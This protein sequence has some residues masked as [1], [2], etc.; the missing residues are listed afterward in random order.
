MRIDVDEDCEVGVDMAPLIDCVFLLLI[1]FLVTTMMKKWETQIPLTVPEMTS[2]LSPKKSA[3][4]LAIIALGADESVYQVVSRNT[5]SGETIYQ[6][7][8][9]LPD[10]L[11]N[12]RETRGVELPLEIAADRT[13]PVSRVIEVFDLCQLR[14]FMQTRVRLGGK[15]NEDPL[16]K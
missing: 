2:S 5:Y 11:A 12:L 4:D 8:G 16:T 9:D 13:V 10:Y 7:I 15:P 1:F 6:P 14:G 3:E